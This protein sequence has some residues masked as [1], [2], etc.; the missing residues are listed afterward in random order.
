MPPPLD[1]GD[2]QVA[3][4]RLG[5]W[6]Q[7]AVLP[8]RGRDPLVA[9][10]LPLASNVRNSTRLASRQAT[11]SAPSYAPHWLPYTNVPPEVATVG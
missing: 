9:R 5:D 1:G 8:Q 10:R 6:P 4:G 7:P 2:E 11:A 3:V